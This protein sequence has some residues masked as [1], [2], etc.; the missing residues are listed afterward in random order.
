[1]VLFALLAAILLFSYFE[2]GMTVNLAEKVFVK[3]YGKLGSMNA[4][5]M[6]V[7]GVKECVELQNATVEAVYN[8]HGGA[9][10]GPA[11][12][13]TKALHAMDQAQAPMSALRHNH[14]LERAPFLDAMLR[15]GERSGKVYFLR[16][17]IGGASQRHFDAVVT[18]DA[19]Q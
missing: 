10:H 4:Y 6:R 2:F 9:C 16:Q 3:H 15:S 8:Q 5:W 11:V 1:M 19:G 14:M 17:E 12:C 18:F 7:C 13:K